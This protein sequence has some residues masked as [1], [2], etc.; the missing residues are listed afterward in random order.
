MQA[1]QGQLSL[2]AKREPLAKVIADTE[3]P[4]TTRRRL[5]LLNEARDFASL[6]LGLPDNGSYRSYVA[7][8]ADYVV[9]NV[10]ATPRFSVE[11]ER[12]CFP[13]AGCVVYRGYFHESAAERYA[14]RKRLRGDDAAVA[15]A[16]AYST[17]G[18]FNDPIVSTM[19]RYND[20]QVV[21]TLFHELAHQLVYVQGDSTFDE[22]FAET[23][24][25]E[26]IARWLRSRRLES[27]D[28]NV[29]AWQAATMRSKQFT[30]LLLDTRERLRKLYASG[31]SDKELAWQKPLEFGRLK[32]EYWRLKASWGGYAGYDAWFDRALNNADLVPIATYDSCVPAFKRLLQQADN[33]MR[34][35]YDAVRELAKKSA[36]ERAAMCNSG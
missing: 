4:E 12:W 31:A 33:D 36:A 26:G 30:R 2:M 16:T 34:R 25:D 19:L 28:A 13:I 6:E 18:H 17:L 15:G 7:L 29:V 11:P 5:Q 10:F 20:I 22:S 21:G 23:V 24:A 9:W 14:R 1:A 27:D 3:T 8:H 35:F 32:Y